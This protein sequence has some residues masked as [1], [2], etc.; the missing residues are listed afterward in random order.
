MERQTRRF[1]DSYGFENME[2]RTEKGGRVRVTIFDTEGADIGTVG[3][4]NEHGVGSNDYIRNVEHAKWF[5][6]HINMI[7]WITDE[8]KAKLTSFIKEKFSL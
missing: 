4:V 2:V 6:E 5:I 7:V 1:T 8:E 3:V